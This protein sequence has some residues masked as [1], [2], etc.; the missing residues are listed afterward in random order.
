MHPLHVH[1]VQFQALSR[2]SVINPDTFDL[3]MG[4]TAAGNP[5]QID[6]A[7]T[8]PDANEQGWKDTIRVNPAEV[9]SIMATFEGFLG[10]YM[11]HCHIIEHEDSEMMR[12]FVVLPAPIAAAMK[13]MAGG[14]H[15][16][17]M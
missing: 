2:Q 12:P 7:V 11:Y 3:V 5:L 16:H 1:L 14:R 6:T 17:K 10:R 9:M 15:T 13:A 4:T 8:T